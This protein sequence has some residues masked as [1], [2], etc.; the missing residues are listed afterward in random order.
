MVTAKYSAV[1]AAESAYEEALDESK[2]GYMK[3]EGVQKAAVFARHDNRQILALV[4]KCKVDLKE[5]EQNTRI[6]SNINNTVSQLVS[7]AKQ[8]LSLPDSQF[9][10]YKEDNEEKKN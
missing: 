9:R 2:I 10:Q 3:T 5:A 8:E 7:A 6:L 1:K 4:N